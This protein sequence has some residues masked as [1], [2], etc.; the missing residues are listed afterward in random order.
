M[1]V[2]EVIANVAL[3]MNGH[4]KGSYDILHPNDHVNKC[5]STNDAYPTGF[6][7]S[8]YFYINYLLDRINLLTNELDKKA[9]S[10]FKSPENGQDTASGRR[11]HVFRG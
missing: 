5:Q 9:A 8:V 4:P 3:E 1:N 11:S 2:N 10:F 7:V 6:R